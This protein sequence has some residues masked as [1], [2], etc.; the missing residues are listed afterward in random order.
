MARVPRTL[1]DRRVLAESY[2]EQTAGI[3]A[4]LQRARQAVI[5]A[6]R[7]LEEARAVLGQAEALLARSRR[8]PP[9]HRARFEKG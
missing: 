5:D 1:P 4:A 7:G 6:Q 3:N 8:M 9:R 2:A